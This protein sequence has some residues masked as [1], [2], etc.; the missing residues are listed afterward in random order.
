MS[1]GILDAIEKR[2]RKNRAKIAIGAGSQRPRYSEKVLEAAGAVD[3][4]EVTVVGG[5]ESSMS[6]VQLLDST[7]I[8]KDLIGLLKTGSVDAVV[9]GSCEASKALKEIRVQLKP[10]RIG[11]IA[12]LKTAH[13]REFF[14]APVGIDEGNTVEERV[15][16]AA[17]GIKLARELGIEPKIGVLS[18]GRKSD[19]GRHKT[20]DTTIKDAERIVHSIKDAGFSDITNY[21]ILVEDALAAGA[22]FIIAPDGVSGNLMF[23]TLAFLGKGRG[24]GAYLAGIEGVYVDTSRA[25]SAEDY[26]TAMMMAAALVR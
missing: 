13:G 19:V 23:R 12:L 1:D 4:A 15:F 6:S 11:R 3:F 9:R 18:G 2:A 24:Y 26:V 21:N 25:G 22:N 14:F 10:K 16:L 5:G 7:S 8:E 17:E 20:V